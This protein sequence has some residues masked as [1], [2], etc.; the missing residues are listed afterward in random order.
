MTP[1]KPTP[2]GYV[3]TNPKTPRPTVDS[4][5]MPAMTGPRPRAD[6]TPKKPTPPGYVPTNPRT[7]RP[8]KVNPIAAKHGLKYGQSLTM[9]EG[10]G[11]STYAVAEAARQPSTL[12]PQVLAKA[13][14]MKKGGSVG[15]A[16]KRADGIAT[17]G[18]TKGKI[19]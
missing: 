18:K 19:C 4:G 8:T 16:S 10:T 12:S 7:P 14:G 13:K 5:S 9:K 11:P 15:S 1:K 2:P 3:P 6:G 17:K